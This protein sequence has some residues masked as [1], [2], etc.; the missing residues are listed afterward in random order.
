MNLLVILAALASVALMEPPPATAPT[1]REFRTLRQMLDL[2]PAKERPKAVKD[3]DRSTQQYIEDVLSES[4][5][6][7]RAEAELISYDATHRIASFRLPEIKWGG[8]D[9]SGLLRIYYPESKAGQYRGIRE[10]ARV[11]VLGEVLHDGSQGK[12][13]VVAYEERKQVKRRKINAPDEE[14]TVVIPKVRVEMWIRP[15]P[16]MAIKAK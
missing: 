3:W 14:E 15:D 6:F 10:N 13:Q 16:A 12:T 2:I 11:L 7:V 5:K 1:T 9:V 8:V 4:V